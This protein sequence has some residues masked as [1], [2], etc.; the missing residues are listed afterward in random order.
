MTTPKVATPTWRIARI[1]T[2]P[3]MRVL[4]DTTCAVR[5]GGGHMGDTA[6]YSIAKKN[7]GA[8]MKRF[9]SNEHS[10]IFQ[11]HQSPAPTA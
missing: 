6:S 5:F 7:E 1:Y 8:E 2:C 10:R 11:G 4:A 9:I 3:C